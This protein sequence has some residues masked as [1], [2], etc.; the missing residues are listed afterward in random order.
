MAFV[1]PCV[2]VSAALGIH[3]PCLLSLL[4]EFPNKICFFHDLIFQMFL[5]FVIQIIKM[6]LS[7]IIWICSLISHCRIS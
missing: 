6:V 7:F 2:R 1:G 3:E 4:G 5:S